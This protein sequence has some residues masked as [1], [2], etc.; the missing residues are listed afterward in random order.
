VTS[1][2]TAVSPISGS[3]ISGSQIAGS[4][5]APSVSAP[6]P[7]RW[8]FVGPSV[9][10]PMEGVSHG[11]FRNMMC[12]QGGLH[13]VCTEFVRITQS[14]PQ[15]RQL[16]REVQK[17]P[18][19][20]LSVQVMGNDVANLA[21]AAA[22][23][24]DAGADVVDINLGCPMPRVVRKGVGAAL[25]KD[26]VLLERV[27]R[28]LRSRT[29]VLMSA[30][31]RAGF[32]NADQVLATAR[33]IEACGAD[34]ISVH[35]R[36][37]CDFYTGVADWRIIQAIRQEV[38]I[39]VVGNGDVWYATDALRMQ[40]ETGCDAV[41]IGRPAL[42]NPW[43]FRQIQELSLGQTPF[44]P[45]GQDVVQHLQ[46]VFERYLVAF[47]KVKRGPLGPLKELL[48]WMA[49]SVRDGGEFRKAALR[50]DD[51][52]QILDFA[53]ERLACLPADALDLSAVPSDPLETSGSA[54]PQVQPL[55]AVCA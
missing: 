7:L 33:L 39:P 51:P 3:Q 4:Q 44:S 22:I 10:A 27:L 5:S 37:R 16:A 42:R 49:R 35:P 54:L 14:R 55:E 9:L 52:V 6:P 2:V 47:P 1:L 17:S 28:A 48:N 34:F 32:D 43:I 25:L 38:R 31:I 23:V 11:E 53:A 46:H 40:A 8:P 18:G 13:L 19:V 21:D 36:R 41:M 24:C 29:R 12:E 45:T 50:L 20:P 30:K 26:L 15:P